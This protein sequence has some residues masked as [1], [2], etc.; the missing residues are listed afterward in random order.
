MAGAGLRPQA[1][2]RRER[3]D[4]L[5]AEI[6]FKEERYYN[7][8]SGGEAAASGTDLSREAWVSLQ[9]FMADFSKLR[10]ELYRLSRG[11]EQ[12][13]MPAI[14]AVG[15]DKVTE[16]L[17]SLDLRLRPLGEA[18]SKLQDDG[19]RRLVKDLLDVVDAL[20]RVF[21]MLE[22]QP[23]SV[24]EGV[25]RG[26]KSVYDL[27]MS[28]LGKAGLSLMPVEEAFNPHWHLAMGTEEHPGRPDG[29]VSRVL[30][31]GFLFQGQVFRTAQVVVVKNTG[32]GQDIPAKA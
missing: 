23:G 3:L 14:E 9:S 29:A 15:L 21:E 5:I 31:K 6:D 13:H 7:L 18:M 10:A 22:R 4:R 25:G 17:R 30:L 20:D 12:I 1:D 2:P 28:V 32:T 19:A 8:Y 27:L 16:T 24:S 11:V 26:L